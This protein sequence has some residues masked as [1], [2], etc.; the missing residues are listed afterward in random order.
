MTSAASAEI[1]AEFVRA[2]IEAALERPENAGGDSGGVP[3]HSHHAAQR[4]EPE[5]VAQAGE[6]LG[7]SVMVEDAF[8]DRGTQAGHAVR[9][10]G[11]DASSVQGKIGMARAAQDLF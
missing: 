4:L 2:R 6:Q 9:E 1:D 7:R 11:G 10:P 8:G 3:I 5:G